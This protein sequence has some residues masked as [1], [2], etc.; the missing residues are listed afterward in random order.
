MFVRPTGANLGPLVPHPTSL[1]ICVNGVAQTGACTQGTANGPGVV[2]VTVINDDRSGR[3]CGGVS[4][5][6]GMAFLIN[7]PLVASTTSSALFYPTS[8]SGW[9]T[10]RVSSPPNVCV[11]IVDS[12]GNTLPEN[13][14]SATVT[15]TLTGLVCITFPST[16]SSCPASAPMFGPFAAGSTFT[17][18]VFIQG[19]Q[20]MAGFDIY[21]AANYSLLHPTSAA[22]GPLIASPSLTSICVNGVAGAGQY[23]LHSSNGPGV[24]EVTTIESSGGTECG[25]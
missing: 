15:T 11:L 22:L 2:E 18:G 25:G 20:A 21:V 14:Q 16:S 7:Y 3:V 13:I 5:C 1:N 23:N 24:V 12:V 9:A 10:S 4:P 6:S 17:I 19:S 8:S